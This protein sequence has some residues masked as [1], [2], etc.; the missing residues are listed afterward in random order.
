MSHLPFPMRP[1]NDALDSWQRAASVEI[2]P[3]RTDHPPCGMP[4]C[5]KSQTGKWAEPVYLMEVRGIS[6]T[7]GGLET[8]TIDLCLC[9]G[10][11]D[12]LGHLA[13][14]A[15]MTEEENHE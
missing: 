14:D 15:L 4:G 9:A 6:R 13:T 12:N 10:C 7:W 11:Y 2:I 1:G 8:S 5:G 3:P